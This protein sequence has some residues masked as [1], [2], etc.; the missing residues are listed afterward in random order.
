MEWKWSA[1]DLSDKMTY[2]EFNQANLADLNRIVEPEKLVEIAS[3]LGKE[4]LEKINEYRRSQDLAEVASSEILQQA[5]VL[6]GKETIHDPSH[7]RENG[8]NG[9]DAPYELGYPKDH[10]TQ[11]EMIEHFTSGSLKSV[12]KNASEKIFQSYL[13]SDATFLITSDI[14]DQAVGGVIEEND[15]GFTLSFVYLNAKLEEKPVIPVPQAPEMPLMATQTVDFSS[16]AAVSNGELNPSEAIA[17][18]TPEEL[19]P[20]AKGP[21]GDSTVVSPSEMEK[22]GMFVVDKST[23]KLIYN[24][25]LDLDKVDYA[26]P[27]FSELMLKK[28][29][30]KKVFANK[31]ATQNEVD[32]MTSELKAV[33]DRIMMA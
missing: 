18:M 28:A 8:G 29:E 27:L 24:D 14:V 4:V 17:Q 21:G 7:T 30:A 1:S 6:R 5:A 22:P 11:G 2:S 10:I 32:D 23:L 25:Y 26:S 3:L 12:V 9:M 33:M 13:D 31:T 15:E 19:N 16:E 20:Y